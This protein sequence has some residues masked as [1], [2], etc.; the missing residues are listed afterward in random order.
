MQHKHMCVFEIYARLRVRCFHVT[1]NYAFIRV[2]QRWHFPLIPLLL[3]CSSKVVYV[4]FVAVEYI[5]RFTALP[6]T[7]QY[8]K[9]NDENRRLGT[10]LVLMR[11]QKNQSIT[12][13]LPSY[14]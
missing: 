2:C 10:L 9:D 7:V 3:C 8:L 6:Q 11:F 5:H 4:P 13:W 12:R 1:I 14:L